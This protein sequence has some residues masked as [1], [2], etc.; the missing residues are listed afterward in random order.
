V[1]ASV[2]SSTLPELVEDPFSES[3][4]D[5]VEL[6]SVDVDVEVA[7][8]VVLGVCEPVL[9]DCPEVEVAV[10]ETPGVLDPRGPPGVVVSSEPEVVVSPSV[11]VVV[12]IGTRVVVPSDPVMMVELALSAPVV[13]VTGTRVVVPS[14][15][16]MMVELA[17]S[18]PVV[19][20]VSGSGVMVSSPPDSPGHCS[21][22][23]LRTA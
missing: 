2:D 20:S 9:V 22:A 11:P 19:V 7:R 3:L 8:V 23:A 6:E 10:G 4:P 21:R 15:P 16:V 12:I 5:E 17:L 14:D 13:V 18:A 1:G